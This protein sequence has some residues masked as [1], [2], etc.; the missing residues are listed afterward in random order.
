MGFARRQLLHLVAGS[1]AL[2]V[3]SRVAWP[4]AYPARP[5][6]MVVPFAPGGAADV[7]A[8]NVAQRMKVP[9]GQPVIIEN[10]TGAR[11]SIGVGRVARAVPDGYTL[12]IG[13]NGSHVLNGATHALQYDL[14]GD[15]EPV[16][17]LATTPLLILAKNVMPADDL[18]GLIAWLRA[19]PDKAAIGNSG[20]GTGSHKAMGDMCRATR[21]AIIGAVVSRNFLKCAVARCASKAVSSS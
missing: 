16:A 19:N 21:L 13:N 7:I 2:P 14:L 5:I 10:V 11:G 12:C 4:Q 17:L 20:V 1:A 9:L 8:R 3:V 18:K 6:T 15:F